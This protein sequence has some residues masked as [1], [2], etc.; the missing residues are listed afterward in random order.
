MRQTKTDTDFCL[1]GLTAQWRSGSHCDL[2]CDRA[3]H[4]RLTLKLGWKGKEGLLENMTKVETWLTM[5]GRKPEAFQ[6][7][8]TA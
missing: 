1:R 2:G 5:L 6:V 7:E 8:E 4:L 3:T